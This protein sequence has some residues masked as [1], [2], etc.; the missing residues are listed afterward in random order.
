MKYQPRYCEENVWHLA[1][2]ESLPEGD[3]YAIFVTNGAR[4]CPL[5][6]QKD[7]PAEDA[8]L[9]WDYHVILAVQTPPAVRIWDLDSRLP[10]G[11]PL[12]QYLEQTFPMHDDLHDFLRP[13]FRVILAA[14][15]RADFAS[16]RSHMRARNGV[17]AA[18]PPEWP[19]I[20]DGNN[21]HEYLSLAPAG[22]GSLIDSPDALLAFFE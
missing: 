3:R 15:Y 22:P 21:L 12:N 4:R 10:L 19:E 6:C 2:D 20:G 8:P 7:A 9:M 17:Y 13:R 11:Y 14:D 5:W 18:P 16:D 1:G